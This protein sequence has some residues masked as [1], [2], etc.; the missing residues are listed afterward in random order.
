VV[1]V[2]VLLLLTGGELDFATTRLIIGITLLAAGAGFIL[3]RAYR[4]GL[5]L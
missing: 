3:A 2:L 1:G 5:N 4:N